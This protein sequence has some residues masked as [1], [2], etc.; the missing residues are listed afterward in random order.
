MGNSRLVFENGT[1]SAAG[2]TLIQ[3]HN[4]SEADTSNEETVKLSLDPPIR[5]H[6][7]LNAGRDSEMRG[8][9]SGANKPEPN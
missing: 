7:I 6:E 3:T 1:K 9:Q 5:P 8:N 4:V 2:T